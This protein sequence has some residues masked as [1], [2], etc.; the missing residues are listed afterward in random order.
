VQGEFR[1]QGARIPVGQA[2]QWHG[3]GRDRD[4]CDD[5]RRAVRSAPA[6]I[7]EGFGRWHAREFVCFLAIRAPR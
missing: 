5:L 1:V 7:A 3:H 4:F 6:N 2:V